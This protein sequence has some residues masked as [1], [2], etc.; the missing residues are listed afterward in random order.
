[1]ENQAQT[2]KAPLPVGEMVNLQTRRFTEQI[3]EAIG[4]NCSIKITFQDHIIVRAKVNTPDKLRANQI[5]FLMHICE[6]W[7]LD[8]VEMSRSGAGLKIEFNPDYKEEQ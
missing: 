8:D 2:T 1:M 4:T 3:N 7:S 6:S 5:N